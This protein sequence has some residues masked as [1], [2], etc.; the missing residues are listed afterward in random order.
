MA[1]PAA[2][3]PKILGDLAAS[4]DFIKMIA[5]DMGSVA[6]GAK[7]VVN[8]WVELQD[9]AFKTARAMNLGREAAM[10]YNRELLANTRALSVQYGIT[11]ENIAEF[12]KNYATAIGRNIHLTRQQISQI[13][14][15][16]NIT[17]EATAQ[18]LVDEFDKIGISIENAF[19]G[20]VQ[21][22]EQAKYL[23]LNGAKASKTLASNIKLAASYSFRNG[24]R[25]IQEMALKAQSVRMDM[26]AVMSAA[27][28]F[29]DIES[30]I[31][32][33]ANIQMLGGS[34]AQNFSNPMAVMYESWADPK[35]LMDRIQKTIEGKGTY[36]KETGD[37]TFDPITMRMMREMAKNLGISVEE[38]TKPAIAQAQGKAV[39]Q[40]ISMNSQLAGIS[41]EQIEA[42]KNLSRSN[43]DEKAGE[44]YITYI[45]EN[46][47]TQTV[48][49]SELTEDQLKVAQDSQLTQDNMWKDVHQIRDLLLKMGDERARGTVSLS[50]EIKGIGQL[51]KGVWAGLI[52]TFMGPTSDAINQ[53]KDVVGE[54][55]WIGKA[56]NGLFGLF[57]GAHANG[58]IIG[59]KYNKGGISSVDGGGIAMGAL[60][61]VDK[62]WAW[63]TKGEMVLNMNQQKGLFSFIKSLGRN[64]LAANIFNSIG[65]KIGIDNLGGMMMM[66]HMG[67]FGGPNVQGV[68]G[69]LQSGKD[70]VINAANVVLNGNISGLGNQT[71]LLETVAEKTGDGNV[72]GKEGALAGKNIAKLR[73]IAKAKNALKYVGKGFGKSIPYIGTILAAGSALSDWSGANSAFGD[74]RGEIESMNVSDLTKAKELDKAIKARNQSRGG[75]V[76]TAVGAGI[77]M[78]LGSA[79]GPLGTVAGGWLG[80]KAGEFI[81][82]GIGGLFTGKNE[83]EYR[84]ANMTGSTVAGVSGETANEMLKVLRHIS[85]RV[86]DG[87]KINPVTMKALT[88]SLPTMGIKGSMDSPVTPKPN[89]GNAM[90]VAPV[91]VSAS[92]PSIKPID[93]APKDI[94]LNVSG[95]IRLEGYGSSANLDVEKLLG[96]SEFVRQLTEIIKNRMNEISNSGRIKGETYMTI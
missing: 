91:E 78:A 5:S 43:F 90:Q 30:S 19:A 41:K 44:H 24:V 55:G 58:G 59:R 29:T 35:A 27:E 53:N 75:A 89:T 22:Q 37:V 60:T 33:A 51:F 42:I 45:D 12:Q 56:I 74:K 63:L 13:A 1:I 52:D 95:S 65:S 23:G 21:I 36:Q 77:G 20:T 49:L 93:I 15:L 11:A 9:T 80:S 81:G 84:K 18:S 26:N 8:A 17:D 67:M 86:D 61:G 16:G 25:D 70:I 38:L 34:F 4:K 31:S 7:S 57:G 69:V 68:G 72:V 64:A 73:K 32:T 3:L 14:A 87:I 54:N 50:D 39:E 96:S 94:N 92:K 6:R 47:E 66:K 10:R 82:K 48:K 83:E 71:S 40:E 28:K 88:L 85:G 2:L 76:G 79:F 62:L 46:R